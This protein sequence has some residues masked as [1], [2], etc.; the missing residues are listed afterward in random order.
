M[1]NVGDF[2]MSWFK[3]RYEALLRY[4]DLRHEKENETKTLCQNI[5]SCMNWSLLFPSNREAV[6][7]QTDKLIVAID[8]MKTYNHEFNL[9]KERLERVLY[10]YGLN[11]VVKYHTAF[12]DPNWWRRD[13]IEQVIS[14]L[15]K[16][17]RSCPYCGS[18]KVKVVSEDRDVFV[19]CLD[20]HARGPRVDLSDEARELAMSKWNARSF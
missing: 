13:D 9:E 2:A 5:R 12:Y 1:K 19:L 18:D 20:C 4:H 6:K 8:E 3:T 15:I 10:D 7:A 11:D 14:D 17:D 16:S